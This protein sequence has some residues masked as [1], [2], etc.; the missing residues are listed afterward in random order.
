[1]KTL[2]CREERRLR[3]KK[4]LTMVMPFTESYSM[5]MLFAATSSLQPHCDTVQGLSVKVL[6]NYVNWLRKK[7]IRTLINCIIFFDLLPT[8]WPHNLSDRTP[9][10][11]HHQVAHPFL[12]LL[13]CKRHAIR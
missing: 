8:Q 6:L 10:T 5:A 2:L 1:M 4:K 12:P 11:C 7:I 13:H 9:L 3:Q